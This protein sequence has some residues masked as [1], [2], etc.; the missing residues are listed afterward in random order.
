MA[1]KQQSLSMLA[2]RSSR[3]SLQRSGMIAS[4]LA[5]GLES[6][7]NYSLYKDQ[8]SVVQVSG[9]KASIAL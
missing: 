7:C 9:E 3:A 2:R 4:L 8:L 6:Y 1:A 5:I